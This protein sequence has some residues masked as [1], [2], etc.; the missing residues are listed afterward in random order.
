MELLV[1][2]RQAS[3]ALMGVRSLGFGQG[4]HGRPTVAYECRMAA[5]DFWSRTLDLLTNLIAESIAEQRAGILEVDY[6]WLVEGWCGADLAL[7][8]RR[9]PEIAAR[10]ILE[11]L[12]QAFLFGVFD[13]RAR[14]GVLSNAANNLKY[15]RVA[16][17]KVIFGGDAYPVVASAASVEQSRPHRRN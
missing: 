6:H 7:Q 14:Q 8:I 5:E 17:D 13:A 2:G 10:A 4:T 1:A 16:E 11:L 12:D 9:R 15:L 3:V